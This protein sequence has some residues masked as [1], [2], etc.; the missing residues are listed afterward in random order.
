MEGLTGK[1]CSYLFSL[2][3]LK[4]EWLSHAETIAGYGTVRQSVKDEEM[5]ER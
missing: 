5:W 3:G 1:S 2:R 4:R